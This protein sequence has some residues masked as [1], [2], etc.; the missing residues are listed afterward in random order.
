[1]A[2]NDVWGTITYTYKKCGC[3]MTE[4]PLEDNWRDHVLSAFQCTGCKIY[5]SETQDLNIDDYVET[6]DHSR[7]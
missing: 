1:M 4:I 6:R 2:I 3:E 5:V 7:D